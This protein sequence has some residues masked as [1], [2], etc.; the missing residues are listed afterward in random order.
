MTKAKRAFN[1]KAD[2]FGENIRK[3]AQ[4]GTFNAAERLPSEENSAKII[5]D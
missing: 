3:V 1:D 2:N 4:N 5:K